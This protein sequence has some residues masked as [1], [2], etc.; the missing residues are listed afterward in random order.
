M[1]QSGIK[2]KIKTNEKAA[3]SYLHQKIRTKKMERYMKIKK[4]Q[5]WTNLS[6]SKP[7][8]KVLF[9]TSM[10]NILGP[11][12][13]REELL[14]WKRMP[15]T[16]GWSSRTRKKISSEK[17]RLKDNIKNTFANKN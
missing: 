14:S 9:L 6:R 13:R 16:F 4:L 8:I 7:W 5:I 1:G 10:E 15:K 3:E 2:A 12:I 11:L 17:L